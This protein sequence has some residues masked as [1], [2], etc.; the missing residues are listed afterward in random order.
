VFTTLARCLET[1]LQNRT[2][3][4]TVR[5]TGTVKGTPVDLCVT[6]TNIRADGLEPLVKAMTG[7]V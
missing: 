7:V 4:R 6:A 3:E 1:W 5:I 2:G